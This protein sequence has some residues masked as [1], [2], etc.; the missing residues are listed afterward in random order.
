MEKWGIKVIKEPNTWKE[1]EIHYIKAMDDPW[2]KL[3]VKLQ[4]LLSIETMK[5]YEEKNIIDCQKKLKFLLENEDFRDQ[6]ALNAQ[7]RVKEIINEKNMA[8]II[9]EIYNDCLNR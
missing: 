6:I 9:E 2:F 4:N 3:L 8:K 1:P 5:F 7:N